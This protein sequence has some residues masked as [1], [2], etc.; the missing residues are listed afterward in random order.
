MKRAGRSQTRVQKRRSWGSRALAKGAEAQLWYWKWYVFLTILLNLSI[1]AVCMV[2]DC[3]AW[4]Q[5]DKPAELA[6]ADV[7][8]VALETN[9]RTRLPACC[10]KP[11]RVA[12]P[13]SH[14]KNLIP[15]CRAAGP[16]V[17]GI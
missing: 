5:Y 17:C 4:P 8:G 14:A 15:V 13:L 2:I 7:A 1:F 9:V 11:V 3:L 6:G 16:L 10:L 12:P